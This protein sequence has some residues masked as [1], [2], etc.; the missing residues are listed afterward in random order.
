MSF[1]KFDSNLFDIQIYRFDVKKL[2]TYQWWSADINFS[3]PDIFKGTMVIY[4]KDDMNM[5]TK[6][7]TISTAEAYFNLIT[8][9][10]SPDLTFQTFTKRL[11]RYTVHVKAVIQVSNVIVY[12]II[13]TLCLI[14][15]SICI[16]V[17]QMLFIQSDRKL[18]KFLYYSITYLVTYCV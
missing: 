7:G 16:C 4:I 17:I 10:E 9:F 14:L 2:S 1:E 15:V 5:A 3:V 6:S 18:S 11:A 13:N 8:R 12:G